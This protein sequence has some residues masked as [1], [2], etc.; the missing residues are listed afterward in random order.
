MI[1]EWKTQEN[2]KDK[3]EIT[4]RIYYLFVPKNGRYSLNITDQQRK[5]LEKKFKKN[6]NGTEMIKIGQ[7][8][9]ENLMMDTL[10]RFILSDLWKNYCRQE[11]EELLQ[12]DNDTKQS[13]KEY[14]KNDFVENYIFWDRGKNKKHQLKFKKFNNGNRL[15]EKM[16]KR[17]KW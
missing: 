16:K 8:I 15:Q 5:L 3:K 17:K 4:T 12:L 14:L 1:Q 13:F 11:F 10:K 9:V 6:D 7:N 2:E